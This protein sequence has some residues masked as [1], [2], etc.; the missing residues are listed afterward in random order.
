M[1]TV[2]TYVTKKNYLKISVIGCR[3][4]VKAE[5]RHSTKNIKYFDEILIHYSVSHVVI[6]IFVCV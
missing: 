3:S 4:Q 6:A 5:E 2:M 1:T